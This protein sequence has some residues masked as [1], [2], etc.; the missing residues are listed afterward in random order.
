MHGIYGNFSMKF[1]GWAWN[2]TG[3]KCLKEGNKSESIFFPNSQVKGSAPI[4]LRDCDMNNEQ[5]DQI[6]DIAQHLGMCTVI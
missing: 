6:Q 4:E 2:E 3:K 5:N 1:L